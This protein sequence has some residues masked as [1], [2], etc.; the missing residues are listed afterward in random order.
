VD[1]PQQPSLGAA[2][3]HNQDQR[4]Y[5]RQPMRST[6][7]PGGETPYIHRHINEVLK[8]AGVPP[9][10]RLLDAGCGAGRHARLLKAR[11]YQVE[12]LDLSPDLLRH[13]D[14]STAIPTYCADIAE[15]P[16][17]LTA[18]YDAVLGFFMLHHLLDLPAAF[19]GI[20]RMVR[21]GGRAVFIE[22]N[23]FNPLYYVQIACTP[24]MRWHAE[25]G[26]LQMRPATL[27][28]AMRDAGLA[29]LSVYRF[30][31]LPPFLRN[32]S[33]GGAVDDAAERLGLLEPVLP[34]QI[35]C[36]EKPH[37]E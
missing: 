20:S 6:I 30:G 12:G 31:F 32:R 27:F 8:A 25:R 9:G 36:A 1:N 34:F 10:A 15:P 35:F 5:Y 29:N 18:R 7:A 19:K 3:A 26:I 23:P 14:G 28:P 13:I 21:P 11:G 33:F 17:A 37:G 2:D 4:D 16:A 22:P 24:R